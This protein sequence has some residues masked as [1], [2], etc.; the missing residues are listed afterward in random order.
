MTEICLEAGGDFSLPL[1]LCSLIFSLSGVVLTRNVNVQFFFR[2]WE[3]CRMNW[4]AGKLA[5]AC[6]HFEEHQNEMSEARYVWLMSMPSLM[7]SST[8]HPPRKLI[9][10][11]KRRANPKTLRRDVRNQIGPNY[12]RKK[13][14]QIFLQIIHE[15]CL[16]QAK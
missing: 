6:K 11:I 13:L 2:Q 7:T 8:P 1:D 15:G 4:I 10:L 5:P 9:A 14:N 16:P 3:V 12:A